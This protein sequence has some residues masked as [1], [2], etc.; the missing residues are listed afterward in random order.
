M[1]RHDAVSLL[2]AV[3]MI[4]TFGFSYAALKASSVWP[5][6]PTAVGGVV[7]AIADVALNATIG[8]A[9]GWW[10][11]RRFDEDADTMAIGG[12]AVGILVA[13]IVW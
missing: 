7:F 2:A 3:A 13:L 11:A 1:T 5:E 9:L 4:A 6:S 12:G 8:G 10:L